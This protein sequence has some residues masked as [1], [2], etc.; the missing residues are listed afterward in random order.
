M[1]RL[2]RQGPP[3][4]EG[5]QSGRR[6]GK[7]NPETKNTL[8]SNEEGRRKRRNKNSKLGGMQG[9][10]GQGLG[11]RHRAWNSNSNTPDE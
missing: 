4:G 3:N 8:D 1:P 9:G 11:K 10:R 6:M 2:D 5:N 7:C